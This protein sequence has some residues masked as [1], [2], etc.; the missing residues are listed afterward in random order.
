MMNQEQSITRLIE[1]Q[2]L[3]IINDDAADMGKTRKELKT[4]D[5]L[6]SQA[7]IYTSGAADMIRSVIEHTDEGGRRR[8]LKEI[9]SYILAA[10]VNVQMTI[11]RIR[12]AGTTIKG[13]GE[14]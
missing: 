6:G 11:Y 7:A 9:Q 14:R 12:E 4:A 13:K 10:G 3:E 2:L 5:Q 1:S 8:Y